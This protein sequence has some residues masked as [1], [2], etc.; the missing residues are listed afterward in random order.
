LKDEVEQSIALR[1]AV[2]TYKELQQR[3]Q[4]DELTYSTFL[5]A[6]QNLV[7]AGPKRTQASL[8][9]FQAAVENG[10]VDHRVVNRIKCEYFI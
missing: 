3:G 9:V 8:D 10:R 6:L 5:A 1:I 7:P 2:A 4:P